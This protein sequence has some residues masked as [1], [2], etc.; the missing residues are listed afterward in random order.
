MFTDEMPWLSGEDKKWIMGRA[1][2]EWLGW[3]H[4]RLA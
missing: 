3:A 2:C 4:P 1:L